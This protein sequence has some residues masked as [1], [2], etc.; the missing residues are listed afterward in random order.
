MSEMFMD[1]LF[2]VPLVRE[3]N[4]LKVF[5]EIHDFIYSHDGLSPQETLEEF[6]KILFI[7]IYDESQNIHKFYSPNNDENNVDISNLLALFES[8]KREFDTVFEMSDKINLSELSLMFIIKKLKNV[9]LNDSSFDAKGLAF[10]KFLNHHEKSDR[11]QFFTPEP[12]IKFCVSI[13]DPKKHETILD[14]ACGSGGFLVAAL[15]YIQEHNLNIDNEYIINNN[16]FGV[17][18]N[19]TIARIAKMKLL[20]EQ[21]TQSNIISH[22]SLENID[23]IKSLI[24]FEGGFDIILTNPPFGAKINQRSLLSTFQLG[25]KWNKESRGFVKT[26]T[27]LNSQAVESLFIERCIDLLKIGG[28]MAIVL[29]NGNFE[30]SSLEYIRYYIMKKAKILA[31]INL[32]QDTFM[33]FGTGIKTSLLF[34]EKKEESDTQEYVVFFGRI[35]KL[36]YQGNKNGTPKYIRNAYGQLSVDSKG[37]QIID[38]DITEIIQ[39][40]KNYRSGMDITNQKTFSIKSTQI[41]NRLDFDYYSPETRNLIFNTTNNTEKLGDICEIVK[42]KSSRLRLNTGLIDYVEL[43]DINTYSFEIINV[44]AYNIHDLPSRASYEMKEGDII[45][46]VAG[47]SVG[48]RKHAT[49]LVS[50]SHVGCICTNG[51]RVLRNFKINPYY[52]LYYMRTEKFLKQ[53]FMYRTGAAIPAVSDTD[54]YNIIIEIPQN[55]VMQDIVEKMQKIFSLRSKAQEEFENINKLYPLAPSMAQDDF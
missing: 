3:D 42:T 11:G 4:L 8:T 35:A 21:N 48:T 27:I 15:K 41:R 17:D 18:I 43:S 50:K 55:H 28:R 13:I 34:L 31:V 26:G 12:I 37:N 10:Q 2:E 49:A 16:I 38:E 47:N 25:Y 32:P 36:G 45:T 44:T 52:L 30:N 6:T 29:P 19:K 46:A 14:P 40:Y 22:N 24:D 53:M 33:P 23:Y 54:V 51:F 5:E 7:K 20:L 9:S 39:L 1:T